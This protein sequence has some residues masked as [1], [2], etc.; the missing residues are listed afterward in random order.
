M[1]SSRQ[2]LEADGLAS[3]IWKDLEGFR[4]GVGKVLE[5]SRWAWQEGHEARGAQRYLSHWWE[6]WTCVVCP[7]HEVC[8]E[9]VI[10]DSRSISPCGL[11]AVCHWTITIGFRVQ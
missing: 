2:G 4:L 9:A 10:Y 5:G 8:L 1:T 7:W 6:I 3:K 11:M